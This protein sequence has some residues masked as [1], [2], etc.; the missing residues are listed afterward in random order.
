VNEEG[1]AV[2]IRHSGSAARGG[3]GGDSGGVFPTVSKDAHVNGGDLRDGAGD[4]ASAER[5]AAAVSQF[6]DGGRAGADIEHAGIGSAAVSGEAE[7]EGVCGYFVSNDE[8]A[9]V[10][11]AV[12]LGVNGD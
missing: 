1:N 4:P 12:V 5:V 10:D 6:A 11:R 7:R 8:W 3:F 9:A 2:R